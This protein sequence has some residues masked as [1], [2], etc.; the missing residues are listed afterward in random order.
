MD[1]VRCEGLKVPGSH[2]IE[3]DL[4]PRGPVAAPVVPTGQREQVDKRAAWSVQW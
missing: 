1:A 3:G 2:Q 4:V